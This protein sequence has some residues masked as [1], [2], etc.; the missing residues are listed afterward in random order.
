MPGAGVLSLTLGPGTHAM[1]VGLPVLPAPAERP[2]VVEVE[3]APVHPRGGDGG[4]GRGRGSGGGGHGGG[5]VAGDGGLV[6]VSP[7]PSHCQS[8]V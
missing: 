4:P 7:P 6:T 8:A 1:S 5:G 2:T 3:P